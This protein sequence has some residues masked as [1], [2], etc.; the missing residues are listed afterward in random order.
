[1]RFQVGKFVCELSV[2]EGGTVL[3][4]WLPETPKYL[5]KEERAQW[6]AGLTTF[7]NSLIKDAPQP[8][9]RRNG[10][11][12]GVKNLLCLITAVGLLAGCARGGGIGLEAT[13]ADHNCEQAGYQLGT[14]QYAACRMELARRADANA[15]AMQAF[16]FRQAELARQNQPH[17]CFYNS[18]SNGGITNGSIWCP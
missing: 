4:K 6:Q 3:A 13:L 2:N 14:P 17:T 11:T 16:Y 9:R 12:T 8:D 1:M 7:L 5:N 18:S 15:A 10:N